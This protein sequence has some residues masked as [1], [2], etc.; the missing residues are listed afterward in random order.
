[1][2]QLEE[3]ECSKGPDRDQLP[4]HH[5]IVA[6]CRVRKFADTVKFNN[7]MQDIKRLYGKTTTGRM[8][9][10]I[11]R[12]LYESET[13]HPTSWSRPGHCRSGHLEGMAQTHPRG[14]VPTGARR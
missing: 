11:W 10:I 13:R 4:Q 1:M 3:R 12:L 7:L 9:L 5:Q 8:C 14:A 6:G 2:S